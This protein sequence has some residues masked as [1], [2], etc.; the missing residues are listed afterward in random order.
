MNEKRRMK[1]LRITTN[2]RMNSSIS[3]TTHVGFIVLDAADAV[4]GMRPV[5]Q[6]S[7]AEFDSNE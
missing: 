5:W 2:P 4:D 1:G 7:I 6:P 3:F